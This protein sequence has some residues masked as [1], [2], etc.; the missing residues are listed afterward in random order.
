MKHKQRWA[1]AICCFVLFI[2]V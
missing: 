2:V 1:G